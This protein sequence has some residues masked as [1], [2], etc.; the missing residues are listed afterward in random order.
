MH[1]GEGKAIFTED[2]L[3]KDSLQERYGSSAP[4]L[5]HKATSREKRCRKSESV[6]S[7]KADLK[8]AFKKLRAPLL[9]TF[10]HESVHAQ[11]KVGSS[12]FSVQDNL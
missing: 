10:A 8:T 11:S 12:E 3:E 9:S 7:T 6:A 5:V 2:D 1:L 4:L